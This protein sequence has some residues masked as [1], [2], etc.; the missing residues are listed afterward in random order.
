MSKAPARIS[1][2]LL[3]EGSMSLSPIPRQER[4][5]SVKLGVEIEED[6][7]ASLHRTYRCTDSR[8]IV[9]YGST[10]E[11]AAVDFLRNYILGLE[12]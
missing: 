5:V 4:L 2:E 12:E 1:F 8:K 7:S 9:G 6:L 10:P 3:V 11:Y